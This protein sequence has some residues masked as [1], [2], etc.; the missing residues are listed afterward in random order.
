MSSLI[1]LNA[2][3][4]LLWWLV[5]N[6]HQEWV[7]PTPRGFQISALLLSLIYCTDL[8]SGLDVN[9]F[10]LLLMIR[11]AA[12]C[13]AAAGVWHLGML[14]MWLATFRHF[15]WLRKNGVL[16]LC[17]NLSSKAF[18]RSSSPRNEFCL[19]SWFKSET[20]I[21]EKTLSCCFHSSPAQNLMR[22]ISCYLWNI[23]PRLSFF[24]GEAGRGGHVPLPLEQHNQHITLEAAPSY[25]LSTTT[26]QTFMVRVLRTQKI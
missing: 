13:L 3:I 24:P 14:E 12:Q 11:F 1:S 23:L 16:S 15:L 8:F 6:W 18:P 7:I 26:G 25:L 4:I 22:Q 10:A 21:E 9:I 19:R 5:L 17:R 20:K 2:R